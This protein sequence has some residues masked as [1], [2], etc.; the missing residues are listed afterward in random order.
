MTGQALGVAGGSAE[1]GGSWA[2]SAGTTKTGARGERATGKVLDDLARRGNVTVLH[3]LVIPV[4]RDRINVDHVVISGDKVLVIDSK[5][6]K[7]GTYWT[8]FGATRRGFERVPHADKRGIPMSLQY[9][10]SRLGTAAK[11]VTPLMVVWPSSRDRQ[12]YVKW[13]RPVGAK[14]CP[15]EDLAG[16]VTRLVGDQPANPYLVNSLVPLLTK[17]PGAATPTYPAAPAPQGRVAAGRPDGGQFA[18]QTRSAPPPS[19]WF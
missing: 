7:P 16:R 3:D 12:V 18:E 10:R 6:W 15:G 1:S 14:S 17:P 5:M 4:G 19:D 13:F 8:L 9:L 2:K 11:Y